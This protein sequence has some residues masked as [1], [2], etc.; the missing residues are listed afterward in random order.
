M[1]TLQSSGRCKLH[2]ATTTSNE[3]NIFHRRNVFSW[4]SAK[5]IHFF[6]EYTNKHNCSRALKPPTPPNMVITS[7]AT[8]EADQKRFLKLAS[9]FSLPNDRYGP[10][11]HTAP[12]ARRRLSDSHMVVD[13]PAE[14]SARPSTSYAVNTQRPEVP[15]VSP[16]DPLSTSTRIKHLPNATLPPSRPHV[17]EP[18]E[19]RRRSVRTKS[20]QQNNSEEDL[21]R[22]VSSP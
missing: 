9:G 13:D 12:P 2:Y 18:I 15:V 20:Q 4:N 21:V 8:R 19:S 6:V 17:P 3:D 16:V 7:L 5:K 10:Y 11:N 22:Q 1:S 14:M